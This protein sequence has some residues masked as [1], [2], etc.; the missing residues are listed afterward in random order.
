M[1]F[2][3][4][5]LS[6]SFNVMNWISP[7]GIQTQA[8]RTDG[9]GL[10]NNGD[11][12]VRHRFARIAHTGIIKPSLVNEFRFGWFKDR[13]FDTVNPELA[14]PNGL[15]GQLSVAGQ[16]N[17]G[18]ASFL[19]RVQPTEDRY[20]FANNLT[21]MVG[22]HN[23]KFGFDIAHTRD[24]LDLLNNKNGTFTYPS[25]TAF[26][27][28]LTNLDGGKRWQQYSQTF[29]TPELS[30]FVRD[31]NFFAQD[32]WRITN[33]LTL[34]Y[35]IRYEYAQFSQPTTSNPEIGRASCRERV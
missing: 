30:V 8:T 29:G 16:G 12:T 34:N 24:V 22:R 35:G 11:S 19:P 6:L 18:I 32:Q 31:Y 26:A 2:R 25:V 28:D 27:Q 23:F 17:L 7:N 4:N 14:P 15:L 10:G 21:W 9:G 13:L 3:S 20:Q 1:L 5:A 33:R